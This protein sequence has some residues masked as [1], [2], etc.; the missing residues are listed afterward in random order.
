VELARELTDFSTSV[1]G[2][3]PNIYNNFTT[4]QTKFE[5]LFQVFQLQKDQIGQQDSTHPL[6]PNANAL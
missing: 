3:F 4:I 1:Q 6:T 5:R 2:N